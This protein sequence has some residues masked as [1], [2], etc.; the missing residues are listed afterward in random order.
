MREVRAVRREGADGDPHVYITSLARSKFTRG[1]ICQLYRMRW[2]SEL[3]YRLEKGPYLGHDQFHARTP[4][5]VRQEV[6]AMMLYVALSRHLM[7]AA[8]E[9]H[10]V[11]YDHLSQKGAILAVSDYLTRL[12]LAHDVRAAARHM[13]RLLER[14]ARRLEPPRPNRSFPRR[15]FK[16]RPRW[17]P[18]GR[19]SAAGGGTGG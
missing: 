10:Q 8:A 7:A 2:E 16:P 15:S 18:A 4:E 19:T 12:L 6:Y 9:I 11:P 14:I 3:F 5:G 13:K 17:T 1:E